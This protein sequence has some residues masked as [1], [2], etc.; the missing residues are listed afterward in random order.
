MT[1]LMKRILAYI[2]LFTSLYHVKRNKPHSARKYLNKAFG[3]LEEKVNFVP[4]YNARILMMEGRHQ[5]ARE[6]LYSIIQKVADESVA[7]KKYIL[8]YF[9]FHLALYE[10]NEAV[11]AFKSEA[12]NL[13]CSGSVKNFLPFFSDDAISRILN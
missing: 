8:K 3:E 7:D 13:N 11:R 9:Q 1:K 6:R 12:I 4:A 2:W 5:E 10:K